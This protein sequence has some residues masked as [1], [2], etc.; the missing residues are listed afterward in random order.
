MGVS[1]EQAEKWEG[2]DAVSNPIASYF[3]WQRTKNWS[4]CLR[5]CWTR[6]AEFAVNGNDDNLEA[7]RKARIGTEFYGFMSLSRE[8]RDMIYKCLCVKG[9]LYIS[10]EW[11]N[12]LLQGPPPACWI[13][14]ERRARGV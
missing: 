12:A 5:E 8:L 6:R 4:T 14:V 1:L 9:Q 10:P 2:V 7:Y 13:Q 3:A 11:N